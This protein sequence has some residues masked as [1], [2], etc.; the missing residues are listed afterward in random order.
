MKF[1]NQ[2]LENLINQGNT[3]FIDITADWC[4]TCK[5]NKILVLNNKEF[6]K[7]IVDNDI[8]LMKG[9]WT[10]PNK[11]ISKFLQNAN[12]YGIPFN[13]LYNSQF[14]NGIIF[15]ELLSTEDIR[16]SIRK[17]QGSYAK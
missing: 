7:L 2:E 17:M 15:S 13:A 9:D 11:E 3:V 16:L 5:A 6:K 1:D 12:R 8:I 14:P 4:I 10:K